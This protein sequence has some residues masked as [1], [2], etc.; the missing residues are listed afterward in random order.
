MNVTG[1]APLIGAASLACLLAL[2]GC[3]ES[4]GD[5]PAEYGFKDRAVT[6]GQGERFSLTVP[7]SP[8][9]GRHWYLTEPRPDATVLKYR[10]K[11]ADYGDGGKNVDG[12]PG[13]TQS[14]RFTALAKGRATVRLLYCPVNT[15]QGP[16][17]T[18]PSTP[19]DGM[20][21]PSTTASPSPY[22]TATGT[23]DTH[24]AFYVFTITVR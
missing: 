20:P 19:P 11:R 23:P 4:G 9:L 5:S 3:G 1:R 8:S 17:D 2:S 6:V 18:A 16:D 14:F 7:A 24:A 10:G 22:P 21:S 12:G 15:C 13:G